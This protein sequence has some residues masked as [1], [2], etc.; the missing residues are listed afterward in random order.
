LIDFVLVSGGF[1][2]STASTLATWIR[3]C[4]AGQLRPWMILGQRKCSWRRAHRSRSIQSSNERPRPSWDG[5]GV[6]SL[7]DQVLELPALTIRQCSCGEVAVITKSMPGAFG[8][9][10][11]VTPTPAR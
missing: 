2:R 5:A 3:C 10:A 7:L 9:G 4:W 1:D 8:L 6:S 11:A